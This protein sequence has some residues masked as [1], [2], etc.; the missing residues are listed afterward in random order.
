MKTSFEYGTLILVLDKK[1]N[2]K[3]EKI[4]IFFPQGKMEKINFVKIFALGNCHLL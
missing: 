2:E 4:A 3:S 1:T